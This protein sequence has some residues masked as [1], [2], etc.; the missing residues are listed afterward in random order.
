MEGC[1]EQPHSRE[2]TVCTLTTE[3]L[4]ACGLPALYGEETA[5]TDCL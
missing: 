5:A 3:S 4:L 1:R 2:E